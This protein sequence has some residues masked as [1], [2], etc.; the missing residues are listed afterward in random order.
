MVCCDKQLQ[1]KTAKNQRANNN[2]ANA[3]KCH[4][5]AYTSYNERGKLLICHPLCFHFKDHS[6]AICRGDED[7]ELCLVLSSRVAAKISSSID[8]YY[9]YFISLSNYFFC[10]VNDSGGFRVSRPR[11]MWGATELGKLGL[12]KAQLAS[13]DSVPVAIRAWA[14]SENAYKADQQGTEKEK[15]GWLNGFI[16]LDGSIF[17]MIPE[18]FGWFLVDVA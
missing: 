11:W 7:N 18:Y 15:F 4:K 17:L 8:I 10:C 9:I 16:S 6:G 2:H 12:G 1:T 13:A 3:C 14:K 5:M